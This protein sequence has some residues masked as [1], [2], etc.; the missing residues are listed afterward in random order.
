MANLNVNGGDRGQA[1]R[2]LHVPWLDYA[3]TVMPT[4]HELIMWWAQ[5][6]WL[7]DGNYRSAFGRVISHFITNVQFPALSE[8]EESEFKDLFQKH[9]NYQREL[10][11]AGSDF[12]C[13]HGD[14]KAVTRKGVFKLRDLAGQTVDVLSQGGVYRKAHFKSF[15]R[16]ELLEVTFSDGRTVLA[17]PEHQW[18]VAKSTGGAVK[19]PTTKLQGRRIERTVA[20]RPAQG[21]EYRAG[22]RHGFVFGDGSTY[23]KHRKTPQ[24]VANFY[25]AKDAEMVPFFE[26]FGGEPRSYTTATGGDLIKIHGLPAEW[27]QLPD[28]CASAEYWYGFVSGF[29]AADGSVDTYGCCILTQKSRATLEAIALQLPRIGMVAGPIRSHARVADLSEVNGDPEGIYEGEISYVTLLKQFMQ[30]QDILLSSHKAKFDSSPSSASYGKFIRVTSVK[31]TGIFD[32]VFCCV[33]HETHS[34]V[35][36]NGVLTGNCYGNV[37]LSIYLPFKR[38]LSCPHCYF[39]QP[40]KHVDYTIELTAQRGV[41]WLRKKPCP[42]CGNTQDFVLRDRKDPDISRIRVLRYSPF[43]IEL[44]QNFW[45]QR[46]NVWWRIPNDF[47]QDILSKARIFVD[48]TPIEVLE[49]VAVNGRL[50]FDEDMIYHVD[51][52]VI[53]GMRT[54]GWGV[55]ASISNFRTFWLQQILNRADQAI[56]SDYTLG[57]RL[58]SPAMA[59]QNDPMIQ[60]GMDNFVGGM[61]RIINAHRAEPM[62]YHTAPYPVNYQFLGGEGKDLLPADKLKFRQQESLNQCNVPLEYHQMTLTAQAAPM[63]LRLFE[64]AWSAVP[65]MYTSILQ[66]IVK[67]AAR[68]FGLEETDVRI[69]RSTIADDQERKNILM[70]LMAANQI[71]PQTA[72]EPLGVLAGDEARKVFKHQEFIQELQKEQDD[73]ALKDQ[74]MGAVSALA[75]AQSPSAMLQQQ[76]QAAQQQ[77]GAGAPPPGMPMGGAPMGGLPAGGGANAGTLSG[78]AS[79]AEQIAGQLAGMPEW[80]RKQQLKALREGN[81]DLHGLVKAKLDEIRQQASSQGQQ[82]L[83]QGGQGGQAPGGGAPQ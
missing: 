9:L 66:W 68:N 77:G 64:S 59:N 24:G 28:P 46:K 38:H 2:Q 76:Q 10:K 61:N 15:G 34:F 40:I 35:L 63:A 67:V 48:D 14:T 33:E 23:N 16:Q 80:D 56:A 26:G 25:G 72:L 18:I 5:Y 31:P 82:M 57:L 51:E 30:P 17:T 13:F 12:L 52:P 20:T 70:Q 45:S 73:K 55:P 4:N 53:S 36:E 78:M 42:Q 79:Q 47:R 21:D 39:E 81:K 37:F 75:G 69:Q 27:K 11:A 43:E 60:H 7:T 65:S 1:V 83:L 44:A 22:V 62:S 74:E 71:S 19:V 50:L 54:R 29:M 58:I 32:E 3:S 41:R 8:N 6:L 49:A